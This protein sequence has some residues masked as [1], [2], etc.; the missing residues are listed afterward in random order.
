MR[1]PVVCDSSPFEP[2]RSWPLLPPPK[3]RRKRHKKRNCD[4]WDVGKEGETLAVVVDDALEA[5][6]KEVAP[7]VAAKDA[8]VIERMRH[9]L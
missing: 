3:L 2:R 4:Y 7:D 9:R 5:A 8:T 6:A 1:L